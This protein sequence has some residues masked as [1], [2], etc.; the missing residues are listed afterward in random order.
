MRNSLIIC[1]LSSALAFSV[2]TDATARELKLKKTG[3]SVVDAEA[4]HFTGGTWGNCVNGQSFQQNAVETF[5]G[6]QYATYYDAARRLCV[7]RRSLKSSE[8]EVI[9][10][11]DYH[12]K[13]NNTHNVSVIG[14]SPRNGAIHLSF[15]HHGHPLHYRVSRPGV[16]SRPKQFAWTADLFGEIT[17][18]LEP[19]KKLLRVTYPRFL[20]TPKGDL[21]F[22]CRIGGSGNGDK[23][24][25]DYDSKSGQWS[26]FGGYAGGKGTYG[27]ASISRNAYLNGLTYDRK[28]RLH[29]TWCWRETGNPMT[30]HDLYYAWSKDLGKTWLNNAGQTIGER[31]KEL[32]TLD[33]TGARAVEIPMN[34]GLM[35]A[36]TQA[37]DSRN[38]IHI[39]TFHLPDNIPEQTDWNST[40][41][42]THY[43][44]YWRDDKGV[45]QRNEMNFTGSR[46]QLWFDKN[47]NAYIVFV[48]DRYNPS[49]NLSIAAASAKSKWNDWKVIHEQRGPFTGQPQVDRYAGPNVFSIYIQEEPKNTEV[50]FSP[51]KVIDFRPE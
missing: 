22:G 35:N 3:E 8:W 30:N 6:F 41:P 40:R 36:M 28:G 11:N 5:N 49:P 7:A 15:D 23:C 46:P 37:T 9:R 16:A 25:A 44:H 32:V 45:W 4:L 19:E 26:G 42:K 47:D 39:L 51:L 1:L 48:G 12:F 13:G 29:V 17:S 10:F 33:S 24:L 50:G 2:C 31:G 34:R 14:I 27:A 38:R 21:Q 18:E 43:F 20:R